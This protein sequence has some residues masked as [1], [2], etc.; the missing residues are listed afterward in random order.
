MV[1]K[2]KI[3]NTSTKDVT[4]VRILIKFNKNE[5]IKQEHGDINNFGETIIII[6]LFLIITIRT[7]FSYKISYNLRLQSYLISFYWR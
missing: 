1:I 3:L 2:G 7:K 4:H 6:I 5:N